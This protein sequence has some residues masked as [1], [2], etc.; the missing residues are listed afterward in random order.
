[1]DS[2]PSQKTS[3]SPSDKTALSHGSLGTDD[4]P[5]PNVARV[6]AP[7]D[8]VINPEFL[9]DDSPTHH[10]EVIADVRRQMHWLFIEEGEANP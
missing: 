6:S 2:N 4:T 9:I 5:F 10:A 1:M 3:R 8:G 7:R